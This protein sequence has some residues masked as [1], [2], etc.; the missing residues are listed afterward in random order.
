MEL[1]DALGAAMAAGY[2]LERG[3]THL[4]QRKGTFTLLKFGPSDVR[5]DRTFTD[6]EAALSAF[7]ELAPPAGDA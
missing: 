1:R 5:V 7:L 3:G 4:Y 6:R 2:D